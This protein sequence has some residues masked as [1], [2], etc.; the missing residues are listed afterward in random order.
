MAVLADPSD[1]EQTIT[2]GRVFASA[3]RR[4]STGA[5][6]LNLTPS[7]STFVG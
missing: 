1:D 2:A 6:Y 5:G 3:M 4:F 7:H